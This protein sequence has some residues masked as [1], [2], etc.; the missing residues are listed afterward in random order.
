MQAARDESQL[1]VISRSNDETRS[2][3]AEDIPSI[4]EAL[5]QNR[6]SL[7]ADRRIRKGR[8][9]RRKD[10]STRQASHGDGRAQGRRGPAGVRKALVEGIS[11]AEIEQVI[12]LAAGVIGFPAT[13]AIFSW[14][15][16]MMSRTGKRK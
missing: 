2:H 16:D 8:S 10:H 4:L 12:A 13:V 11:P 14:T 15:R 9:A 7:G 1:Q 5:P 3:A 6:S